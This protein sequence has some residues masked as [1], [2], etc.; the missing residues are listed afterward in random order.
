MKRLNSH[1]LHTLLGFIVLTACYIGFFA[2]TNPYKLPISML[3]MPS[4][5][6]GGVAY[7]FI[8]FLQ[9]LHLLK[10]KKLTAVSISL[11][12]ILLSLL[13][14]LQQFSWRDAVLAGVLLWLFV[15]YFS[16]IHKLG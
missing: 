13:A 4:L 3:V 1:A 10:D 14:S 12:A 2:L 9:S 16:R 11:Y 7:L 5:L 6:L 8:R 15:F